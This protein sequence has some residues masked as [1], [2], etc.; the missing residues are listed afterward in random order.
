MV[1]LTGEQTTHQTMES[2][3]HAKYLTKHAPQLSYIV[4]ITGFFFGNLLV[5]CKVASAPL[6]VCSRRVFSAG[7]FSLSCLIVGL[8]TC[9]LCLTI[10][11][12]RRF[13]VWIGRME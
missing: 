3:E 12:S 8:K 13:S 10:A 11:Q 9:A 6:A 5:R 4:S 7:E 2:P 1:L